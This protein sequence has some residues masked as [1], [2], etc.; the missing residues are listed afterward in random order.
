MTALLL[1]RDRKRLSAIIA[2]VRPKHSLEARL[3][4]LNETDRAQYDRYVERM[5]AFIADNDIDPDG[6]PGNAY[7]MT[8]R[9][10][11]PQLTRA[12]AAA[13]FG[14]TPKV[15]LI[16]TDDTAARRYMEFCDEQ[17]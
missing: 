3:D 16:D 7:A 2:I 12:I 14:E 13:L 9:G 1:E 6:D 8:L 15:L 4:A 17:R 5:S 10:Y 11:G